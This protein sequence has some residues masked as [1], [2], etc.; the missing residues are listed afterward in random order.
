VLVEIDE[1][2]HK[3]KTFFSL[4]CLQTFSDNFEGLIK[5]ILL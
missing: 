2:S 1:A 5:H 4:V 3:Q